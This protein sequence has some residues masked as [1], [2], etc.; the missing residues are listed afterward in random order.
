[1]TKITIKTLLELKR[2]KKKIVA[3]TSYDRV[4]A[5]LLDEAGVDILLI[6]DSVGMVKLGLSSTLPVTVEDVAYHTRQVSSA[7]PKALVV[8]DMPFMSYQVSIEEAIRNAGRLLKEGAE[9]VKLE[10]GRE[11]VPIIQALR[12][13]GIPVM[14]HVGMTPQS[15]HAFGGYR[16]QGRSKKQAAAIVAD[17]RA[18]E[19][20]GVFSMVVEC[21]P[22]GLGKQIS[23]SVHVPTIGIGAG[24][25]CDGQILV[26]DDLL[27]LTAPPLPRFAKPYAHLRTTIKKAASDYS[28]EVRSGQYPGPAESYQ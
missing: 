26:V 19:R 8:A 3:L 27:G 5:S 24:P 17:A 12:K 21:V 20:A 15:V 23:K 11:M 6:G 10:G 14:G 1:M 25:G 22:S 4:T 28:R 2:A 16:V 7:R 13:I 18:I 9:A